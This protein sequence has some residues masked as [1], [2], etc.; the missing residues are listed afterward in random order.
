MIR[1]PRRT[2]KI[3]LK[4]KWG[5]KPLLFT[6]AYGAWV[7]FAR[8]L[9]LTFMT[10]L[11]ISPTSHFQDMGEAFS[12]NEVS[13]MGLASFL[14]LVLFFWL[15]PLT[16]ISID[17][18]IS[19][20]HIEKLFLPGFIKGTLFSSG[21]VIVFLLTGAYRN[22]GYL[23]QFHEAPVELINIFLRIGALIALAYCEEFYFRHKLVHYFSGHL[24]R[25]G[26]ATAITLLYCAIKLIQFDLGLMH[27]L[28]LYLVSMALTYRA[29]NEKEFSTGAGIWAGIL[30]TF[31][32][33]LSLPILGND[34][35]GILLL[36][37]QTLLPGVL[38]SETI[39]TIRR[40]IT[41]GAGGPLS[42]FTFQI[43]IFLDICR[44]ILKQRKIPL[45]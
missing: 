22:L 8:L 12:S 13:L 24:S 15:R 10:Y 18:I 39:D 23:I 27:L 44:S 28:S 30:T 32:P 20:N 17:E 25:L 9:A 14:F 33:L 1:L 7:F 5:S 35:S 41:G 2:K 34:F 29:F 21:L 43:F 38:P 26:I 37:P 19:R 6:L 3:L 4:N 11:M 42:S 45:T 36:K 40:L 31:H 16:S